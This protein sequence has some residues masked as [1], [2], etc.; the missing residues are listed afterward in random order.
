MAA[1]VQPN[2]VY[3][4]DQAAAEQTPATR[5]DPAQ[6]QG[7]AAQYILEKLKMLDVHRMVRGANIP[8]A[9]IDSQI[10]FTHPDLVGVAA[11]S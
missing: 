1:I 4:L 11:Q 7:D 6:Q 8:I 3:N 2:Y 10:D 5:G 9:V